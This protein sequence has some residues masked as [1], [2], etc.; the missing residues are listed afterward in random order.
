MNKAPQLS[1][2][3]LASLLAALA[4]LG[5]FA[6]DTYLP[7]FPAIQSSLSASAIEVQQTLTAY[8]LSFAVMTL[9]HGA[10]SDEIGRAHV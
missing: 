6:I 3:A 9:W 1:N 2:A 8:M 10:L 7:A 5:P 4:M